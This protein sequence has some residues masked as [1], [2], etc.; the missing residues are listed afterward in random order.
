MGL[1]THYKKSSKKQKTIFGTH[2]TQV[3][4]FGWTIVF[5][6]STH[7]CTQCTHTLV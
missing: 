3:G 4:K 7:I 2:K 5:I 1:Y 6:Y